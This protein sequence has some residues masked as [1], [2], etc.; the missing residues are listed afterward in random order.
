MKK[1]I[2][3]WA[4]ALCLI[5]L[6]AGLMVASSCSTPSNPPPSKDVDQGTGVTGGGVTGPG[7]TS[8]GPLDSDYPGTVKGSSPGSRGGEVR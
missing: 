3:T 7:V 8:S 5:F 6:A 1:T 4:F 2:K